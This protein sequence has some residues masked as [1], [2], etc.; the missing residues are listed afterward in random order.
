MDVSDTTRKTVKL[1]ALLDM[2]QIAGLECFKLETTCKTI[3]IMLSAL[4]K[5]NNPRKLRFSNLDRDS[6]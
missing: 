4:V 5:T 2:Y 1:F 6:N 3:E